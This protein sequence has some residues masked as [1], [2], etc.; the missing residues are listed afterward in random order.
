MKVLVKTKL[1]V[2]SLWH[3]MYIGIHYNSK[4][5]FVFIPKKVKCSYLVI[6]QNGKSVALKSGI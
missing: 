5:V 1:L 4:L 3:V 2:F 6:I